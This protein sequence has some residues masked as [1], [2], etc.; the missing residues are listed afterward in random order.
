MLVARYGYHVRDYRITAG[1]ACPDCG[2]PVPGRWGT[3]FAG[4]ITSRPFLPGSRS[5]LNVLR[6]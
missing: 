4:Q 6:A 1:G 5:L 3:S 2:T